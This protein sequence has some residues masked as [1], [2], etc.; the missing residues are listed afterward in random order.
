VGEQREHPVNKV[1]V[2]ILV[3]SPPGGAIAPRARAIAH[4]L[5]S[6]FVVEL[7][8]R[9]S[10]RAGSILRF[11]KDLRRVKADV[12][13]L[14]D[15][16]YPVV[17]AASLHRMFTP[18]PLVIDTGDALA[19]LLWTTGR[20]GRMGRQAVRK[21]EGMVLRHAD[22]VVVRGSGLKDY[23]AHLGIGR[24]DV[25]P[26]G[27]DTARFHPMDVADLRKALGTEQCLAV[28]VMSS[29][30]WSSRLQWG[31]GCELIEILAILKDLPVCG[32]VVGD[33]PGR[34]IL[35]QRAKDRGVRE[36]IR[37]LGHVAFDA[38]PAHINA[39]DICLST[40][41]NDW[42][43]RARTTGKLPL[44]LS[45]G[46][47][48]LASRVGEAARVLPEEMLVDYAAGFDPAYGERLARRIERLLREPNLLKLGQQG[49]RIAE[50]E[51]DYRVIVPRVASVLRSV[52][53]PT[54]TFHH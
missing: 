46:R 54:A 29:L 12:L 7:L 1:R 23:L 25:V 20:V 35:E 24:V 52:L 3:N 13:Y 53:G 34:E 28:G 27:V 10:T 43:G 42:V 37:F 31:P 8:W 51:F 17:L 5:A 19:E 11:L 50:A 4:G 26:D 21:Y 16:G 9:Q 6:E 45:C 39:M 32:L 40:Q 44:F 48:I 2:A 33:G 30:G 38:L 36:R 14:L 15:I 18:S 49:R 47:F 22:H 41:T